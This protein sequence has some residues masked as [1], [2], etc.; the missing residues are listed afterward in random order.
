M[1][2][3]ILFRIIFI[4]IV[5][6]LLFI[7]YIFVSDRMQVQNKNVVP[8]TAPTTD[9]EN[10][11]IQDDKNALT[12]DRL[13]EMEDTIAELQDRVK[14][15]QTSI[16]GLSDDMAFSATKSAQI[17]G[18]TIL[19][20]SY[21]QVATFSTASTGFSPMG[22]FTN[23]KCSS[24][25]VLLITFSTISKNSEAN[26]INSYSIYLNGALQSLSGETS[27]PTA[28]ASQ[29]V[30]LNGTITVNAGTYT[31]EVKTKT[32]GGTATS[33]YSS[34]QVLAVEY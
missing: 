6:V 11:K 22:V 25:C 33:D 17:A 5:I 20:T 29:S 23:I 4:S 18:K 2:G 10:P 21:S 8:Q 34:L 27:I 24:K 15:Q 1:S 26:N 13:K 28:N 14:K 3:K 9:S 19:A 30:A 7:I 32:N 16:D 12:T 31:V